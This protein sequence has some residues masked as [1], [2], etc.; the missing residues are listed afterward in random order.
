MIKI[1]VFSLFAVIIITVVKQQKPEYALAMQLGCAAAVLALII[2]EIKTLLDFSEGFFEDAGIN[3]GY[4]APLLKALGIA[5]VTQFASDVCNDADEKALAGAVE[6]AGKTFILILAV[7]VLKAV[8]QM[9][10][11]LFMV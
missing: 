4:F 10:M 9:A 1:I 11:N 3:N 2:P 5:V 7:P 6:L 8:M